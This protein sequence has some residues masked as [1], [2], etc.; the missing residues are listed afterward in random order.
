MTSPPSVSAASSFTSFT[1]R[2]LLPQQEGQ[3]RAAR[4][5]SFVDDHNSHPKSTRPRRTGHLCLVAVLIMLL[6]A[7]WRGGQT[8]VVVK[9][10]PVEVIKEVPV[11]RVVERVV[12]KLIYVPKVVEVAKDEGTKPGCE[13]PPTVSPACII[14]PTGGALTNVKRMLLRQLLLTT[15]LPVFVTYDV[16]SVPAS[17]VRALLQLV[18]ARPRE[19][20]LA[21]LVPADYLALEARYGQ[22]IAPFGGAVP[23]ARDGSTLTTGKKQAKLSAIDL[24]ASSRFEACWHLEDDT[25]VA[26]F[27]AVEAL[28][29]PNAS[30]LV[31]LAGFNKPFWW[32]VWE[33]FTRRQ[34]KFP[35]VIVPHA[36]FVG[37]ARHGLADGTFCHVTPSLFRMS[38]RF[39]AAVLRTV[40]EERS[41]SHHEIFLPFV[42]SQE[43][44]RC[45]MSWSP[46]QG[47]K[48][49]RTRQNAH[50]RQMT[51]CEFRRKAANGLLFAHPV[52]TEC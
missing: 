34:A 2:P 24:C 21:G 17:D 29:A 1:T 11:E 37:D 41:T 43:R 35:G 28:H 9:E 22:H 5:V 39:A 33:Q 42:L 15:T 40:R 3:A 14:V 25:A 38:R 10:V 23:G 31:A 26:N 6:V 45:G 47:A 50:T 4:H 52:K 27:S 7:V 30:D 48:H 13:P 8:R 46:L 51:L 49:L 44:S 18:D 20:G 32:H 36:S 12:E 16:H 19:H